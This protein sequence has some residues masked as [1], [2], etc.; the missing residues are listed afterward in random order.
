MKKIASGKRIALFAG[1]LLF[2]LGFAMAGVYAASGVSYV[3]ENPNATSTASAPKKVAQPGKP[4]VAHMPTPDPVKAIYMTQCAVGTPSL[5]DSLVKLIDT[6]E[7][8]AVIIDIRDYTGTIAFPTDDP[9]LKDYV[10]DKCGAR[11]MKEF[12]KKLHD[13]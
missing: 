11:D 3:R 8:N 7:L 5:R 13:K 9:M 1:G 10:S 6:T 12:I 4:A 2:V